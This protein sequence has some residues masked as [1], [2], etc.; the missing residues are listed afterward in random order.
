LIACLSSVNL[1]AFIR[2]LDIPLDRRRL[3]I[4]AT[5]CALL[6]YAQYLGIFLIAFQIALALLCLRSGRLT[7]FAYG[8]VGSAL[9][10]PWLIA[11]MGSSVLRGADPLPHISWIGQ[12][13]PSLIDFAWFYVSIFGEGLVQA[14]WL[15]LLLAFLGGAYI[16]HLVASKSLPANH[17]LLFLIGV[18]LPT[19]VYLISVWGPKP[20]FVGRQLLGAAIAFV[21]AI[22][23]CAATLPKSLA[24]GLLL[25]LLAWTTTGL[26]QGFP[27]NTRP[28]WKELAHIIDE[29]YGSIVVV[30][31]EAW[32][33]G[34]LDYYR[35]SGPVRLWS[36]FSELED[37]DFLFVCRPVRSRCSNVEIE[38]LKSRRSLVLTKRWGSEASEYTELRLYEIRGSS[39]NRVL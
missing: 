31:Q 35:K 27:H 37:N 26:P 8:S 39:G 25:T 23:L 2:V 20:V 10:L 17:M 24:A 34:P 7:I 13:Q 30:T 36:E 28:P 9:I 15:L 16:K 14:R 18:G 1:L 33:K 21:A 6:L 32:V 3:A 38:A 22:G 19:V 29:R 12:R 4:W 11:A 5:S